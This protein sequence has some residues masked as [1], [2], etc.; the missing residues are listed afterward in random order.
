MRLIAI[1]I[2]INGCESMSKDKLLRIVNSNYIE[3]KINGDK[4]KI[5]SLKVYLDVIRPYLSHIINDHKTQGKW[6]IKLKMSIN[7]FPSKVSE[8]TR[9]MYSLSDKIIDD[10]FYSFLESVK[11]V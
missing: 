1:N 3:N 2:N 5:L 8:K 11:K 9:I 10:L 6:K 4:G 7:F